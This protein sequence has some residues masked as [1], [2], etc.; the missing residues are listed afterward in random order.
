MK[1]YGSRSPKWLLKLACLFGLCALLLVQAALA[2]SVL[3]GALANMPVKEITVFKDGHVFVLHEGK[4]PTDDNGDVVLDYLPRPIIGTFWAYSAN[5]KVKLSAV[6]SGKRIVSVDRT[7]L[8]IRELIEGNVGA[9]VQIKEDTVYEAT[10]VRI[11]GRTSEE[12][13]RTSA[14][15]TEDRLP[16]RGDIV[17][18]KVA[19][20][21]KAVPISRIQEVIFLDKP[22]ATVTYEEFRNIMTL[23]LDRNKRK[24]E[25]TADV[26]MVY[27]QRGI[28]WIPN[29]HVEIDGKGNAFI[30]LQATLINE[31][32]DIENVKAHLVIGV[33]TFAFKDTVDPISLQETVAQLSR[34][35]REDSQ[36]A[37]A[38]SNAIMS[39]DAAWHRIDRRRGRRER[40]AV[41]LGP[42]VTGSLKNEDLY[43]FTLDHVTL[44][45]GQRMVVPVADYKLK[46]RDVFVLDLPFGPP[47]EVRHRFNSEQQLQ[48]AR[49]MSAP[50][51]VH[52]I[53]LTND[54]KYPLTTAPALIFREG[55][56]IAQ[57]MTSYTAIGAEGDL[58]LTTAV[59]ISAERIDKE[60]E[61]TPNAVTWLGN[62][63]S[64]TDMRG[65]IKLTNRREDKVYLE[66]TRSI[67][68]LLDSANND[69][70]VEQLGWH[71]GGWMSADGFPFWWY[72][73]SWPY[74]WYHFNGIGRIT[75]KFELEPGK[76]IGLEYRWHYFWRQ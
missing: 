28:R 51:V 71:E 43:V 66:V 44:K 57:G 72:W 3:E 15:G 19:E 21:I 60:T 75:W 5:P 6:V 58:E 17:L 2:V 76:S 7:A 40:D 36:T 22:Q 16:A 1:Q 56:I 26:G 59:D 11:P 65:D 32:A 20:G 35:F 38:F 41:D 39:Q 53:R 50:K 13:R 4:A 55:R 9:R 18:L 10:V 37:F 62:R 48:L 12:L 30:K 24:P 49:R 64:K 70:V 73:H 45:K 31:L 25:K 34:H 23:K 14:P 27:V 47:P 61:R 69:G 54:S 52:R 67:L 63:Y 74:W 42:E 8:T 29:Y 68:G 46:Y 33:P